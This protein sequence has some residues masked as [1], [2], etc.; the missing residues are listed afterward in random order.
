MAQAR[1]GRVPKE[2]LFIGGKWVEGSS[3]EWIESTNPATEQPLGRVPKGT[4][5][6]ARAALEAAAEAQPGWEATGPPQRAKVLYKAY[7]MIRNNAKELARA[8]S[9]EQGKP[10]TEAEGEIQG[11]AEH[12]E[13]FAGFGRRIE[14]SVVPS[15]YPDHTVM[16]IRMPLG[17]VAAMTPWNFPAAMVARKLCPSLIAG[18]AVV[19][20]PSSETPLIAY[21]I[22]QILERAGLPKGVLNL[23]TGSG[24]EVG[25]ELTRNPITNLV[26]ITGSTE[27]GKKVMEAASG[28][29]KRLVLELGGKAP[30]IVW[31]DA[32]LEQAVKAAVFAR[33]WN[34]GQTCINS[35]RTYVQDEVYDEFTRKYTAAV[36]NL[37]IGDPL[38]PGT[39]IGPLVS[40]D[41]WKKTKEAVDRAVDEGAEI[42]V[43]GERPPSMKRG[44]YFEPTVLQ[45]VEQDSDIMQHE[46]FG[47][48]TPLK[49]FSDFDE[50]IRYAN[51]SH[52]GLASYIFT[53]DA[54]VAM[55][56]AH[57]IKFGE[58]YVNQVGPELLQGY[59]TG[60]R[61]SGLGGEGSRYGFEHYTQV[62][63]VYWNYSGKLADHIFPYGGGK[64]IGARREG[65]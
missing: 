11:T 10:L 27:S 60:F 9:M 45:G 36:E 23:V 30:F 16:M 22:V 37:R 12:F 4:R 2:K 55:K 46:V 15:D 24:S 13:Y 44:Y 51:D 43:G 18:N 40:E 50:V 49:E 65:D 62:K 33:Y 17:V 7:D 29:I 34:A 54:T 52:Y 8:L 42:L 3:D 63:T 48:V 35:E 5:E 39:D 21:S 47:P 38:K 19:L 58:T 64:K 1:S 6:D 53:R 32:D 57:A 20:K 28:G 26:T 25:D 41:Q 59:H 56:A 61:E 14:G 31:K